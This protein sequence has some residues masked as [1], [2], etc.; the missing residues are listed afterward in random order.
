V[1]T[2]V[3]ALL[4]S[5]PPLPAPIWEFGAY[6]VPGQEH[7]GS[8]RE[9]LHQDVVG[10]DMRSG[11][12]VDRIEDLHALSVPDESIGTALLLD[13]VEHV[14]RPWQALAEVHRVLRPGGVVIMTSHLYFPIHAHPDD[15]W[16][17]T[18]SAFGVLLDSYDVISLVSAGMP[19]LPHTIVGVAAKPPVPATLKEALQ[20]TVDEWSKHGADSWKER[21]MALLPP[22]V[23]V[24]AYEAFMRVLQRRRKFG[25]HDASTQAAAARSVDASPAPA[26]ASVDPS[27]KP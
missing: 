7:R 4:R 19:K 18:T 27:D 21:I 5:L 10:C 9:C 14:A 20:R 1:R 13:T 16:R 17:F 2:T 23:M 25:E 6:R 11:P 12:G 3:L 22:V 26:T 15:Y 24:P 8:V